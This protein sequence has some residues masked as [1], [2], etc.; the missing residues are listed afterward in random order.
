MYSC[1][2]CLLP[3]LQSNESISPSQSNQREAL[4]KSSTVNMFS[5]V[6]LNASRPKPP[7]K[8][9]DAVQGFRAH[10]NDMVND[11]NT[12]Y[13]ALDDDEIGQDGADGNTA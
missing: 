1:I 4:P 3:G 7:D 12:H 5:L 6:K 11:L 8:Y 9:L 2:L 10:L 13:P